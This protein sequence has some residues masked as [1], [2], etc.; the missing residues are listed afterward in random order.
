MNAHTPQTHKL[1]KETHTYTYALHL[2]TNQA[3]QKEKLTSGRL[4]PKAVKC[5]DMTPIT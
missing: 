2:C 3:L 5:R 4:M 1:Y